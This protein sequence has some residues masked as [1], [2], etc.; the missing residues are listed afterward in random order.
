MAEARLQAQQGTSAGC[1]AGYPP[2]ESY[3]FLSDAQTAALIGPDGAVEW[4]C[5]PRFD[6]PS[7]FARLLDR[8]RGGAFELTVDGAPAPSRRYV[9]GS[10]VLESR[11][12]TSA[13]SVEVFDFMALAADGRHG[14]G[15][16]DPYC[17]LVRLIHCDRGEA[18]VR[19]RIEA[20]PEYGRRSAA[21]NQHGEFSPP[22]FL[23]RACG[24]RATGS[25]R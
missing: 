24:P 8:E 16:V 5:A 20:R 10:L 18:R 25:C 13:G 1:A 21:W 15:E 19:A 23:A 14:A 9:D 6:R 7:V 12:E 22:R 17:V 11:F 2:I 4:L 3:A